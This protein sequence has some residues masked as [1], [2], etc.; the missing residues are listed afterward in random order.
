MEV[1]PPTIEGVSVP[2]PEGYAYR[3]TRYADVI[4]R[5][6]FADHFEDLTTVLDAYRIDFLTEIVAGGGNRTTMV[7]RF[8]QALAD[9]GWGKQNI[10]IETRINDQTIAKVR[11]HEID[12]MKL[13]PDD[14][15]PGVAEETEWNNKDTFFDRDLTNFYTL[16]RAGAIGVGVI[17]TRGPRL[18][19]RLS[20]LGDEYV[21]DK[22]VAV[23]SKYGETTTHWYE[24]MRRVDL[25]GGGE[26]PM[27]LVGI[28]PERI[29][30]IPGVQP[31]EDRPRRGRKVVR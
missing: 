27:I 24:L 20:R 9:R 14:T 26:C 28:E 6:S 29:D 15:F 12:M 1:L 4:L 31:G 10:D 21:S 18:Q 11:S 19:A 16:H 8:D 30:G 13:G 25:G 5:G 22:G 23:R 7:A 17:V 2:L 3:V